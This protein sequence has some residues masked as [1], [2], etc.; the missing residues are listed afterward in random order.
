[1]IK[2][3]LSNMEKTKKERGAISTLVLFTVFMFI[4]ILLRVFYAI[5]AKQKSQA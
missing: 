1:M 4:V 2:G 5:N 3:E